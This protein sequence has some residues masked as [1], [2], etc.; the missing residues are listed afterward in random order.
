MT[1]EIWDSAEAI[2]TKLKTP[3]F[4]L[5]DLPLPRIRFRITSGGVVFFAQSGAGYVST[6]LGIWLRAI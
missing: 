1:F 5:T 6:S 4:F 3:L 2:S